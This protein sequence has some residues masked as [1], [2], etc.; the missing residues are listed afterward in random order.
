HLRAGQEPPA[1]PGHALRGLSAQR[2]SFQGTDIIQPGQEAPSGGTRPDPSR[3]KACAPPRPSRP[4]AAIPTGIST[5]NATTGP[6]GP[7]CKGGMGNCR[8][9]PGATDAGTDH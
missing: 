5:A 9:D 6:D 2:H 4:G 1:L 7:C 3:P 8:W